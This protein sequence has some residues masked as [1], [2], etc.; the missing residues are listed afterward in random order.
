MA[1]IVLGL[2]TA[3]VLGFLIYAGAIRLNLSRLFFWTG[4]GLVVIAAGVLRYAIHEL[5]EVNWLPG[6]DAY[7]LDV[8]STIDPAGPVAGV[9]RA[10]FNVVP[11]MTLLELLAWG[12]YLVFVMALFVW[13][14]R[15]SGARPSGAPASGGSASPSSG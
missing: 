5:Q 8:S 14:V 1:R 3:I 2:A 10:V 13:K 7:V 4:I 9:I 11:T 6:K 15:G 12:G